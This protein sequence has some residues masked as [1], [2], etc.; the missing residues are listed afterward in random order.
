M[1]EAVEI[2]NNAS[3]RMLRPIA[4]G[5]KNWIFLGSDHGGETAAILFSVLGSARLHEIEPWA[6]MRDALE[7]V[8]RAKTEDDLR[9]MLPDRWIAANPQHRLPLARSNK[10]W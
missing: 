7:R 8:T 10:G 1:A 2:D 3:E 6:C 4:V 5:R 9:E